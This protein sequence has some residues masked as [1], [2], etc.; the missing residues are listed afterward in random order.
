MQYST[1]KDW[2]Q[3][4]IKIMY[5]LSVK[6]HETMIGHIQDAKPPRDAW[7]ASM[8]NNETHV[9]ACKIQLKIELYTICMLNMFVN[10]YTLK[11]KNI[12]EFLASIGVT[13]DDDDKVK[14]FLH[15][16]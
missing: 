15:G 9:E 7:D 1:Y 6:V 14:G 10:E 5:Y 3:G 12:V 13:I 16:P 8:H 2:M 11:M 4:A